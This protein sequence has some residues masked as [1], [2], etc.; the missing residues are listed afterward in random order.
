MSPPNSLSVFVFSIICLFFMCVS[1]HY[2]ACCSRIKC[3]NK[4]LFLSLSL[5]PA[6]SSDRDSVKVSHSFMFSLLRVQCFTQVL[7]KKLKNDS[8]GTC[9]TD[10]RKKNYLKKTVNLFCCQKSF[11]F[12]FFFFTIKVSPSL[13]SLFI[14]SPASGWRQIFDMQRTWGEWSETDIWYYDICLPNLKLS[15]MKEKNKQKINLIV[16]TCYDRYGTIIIPW[17]IHIYLNMFLSTWLLE[18]HSE[19]VFM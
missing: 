14:L 12:F 5:L 2:C 17:R 19:N 9:N 13:L 16:P 15:T 3:L 11:F 6:A 8:S 7:K 4:L 10:K 1:L 18:S